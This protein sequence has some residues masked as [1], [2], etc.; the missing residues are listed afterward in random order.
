MTAVTEHREAPGL[1][2]GHVVTRLYDGI[3]PRRHTWIDASGQKL[4][5]TL[6]AIYGELT[7]RGVEQVLRAVPLSADD[8]FVDLGSGLGKVVLQ[9]AIVA[10]PALA[11]GVEI[12][13]SRH[14][15]AVRARDRAVRL[16]LLEDS[17][18]VFRNENLLATDLDGATV[19]FANALCFSGRLM[20]GL[21]RRV[22]TLGRPVT[23]V[24]LHAEDRPPRRLELVDTHICE[25]SW[26]ARETVHVY[27]TRS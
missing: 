6:S 26:T 2:R 14:E 9:V 11:I 22:T 1:P 13:R 25:T 12:E 7:P 10:R 27:R 23:F 18:C 15:T 19:L 5:P 3:C 20:R 4:R 8:V 21:F 17:R 16:G 24:S